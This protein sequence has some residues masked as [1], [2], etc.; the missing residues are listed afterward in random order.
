MSKSSKLLP[1]VR[2]HVF[3]SGQVQG[4]GFRWSTV[5]EAEKFGV[6][7]WVRNLPDGRVEAVFEGTQDVV[8]KM[9]AWCYEGP[10]LSVVESVEVEYEDVQFDRAFSILRK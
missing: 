6:N 1:I 8:D 7:G 3:V 2:A 5:D 4:V 10:K 9:I